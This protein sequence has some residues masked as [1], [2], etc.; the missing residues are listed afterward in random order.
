MKEFLEKISSYNLFN[1]LLPGI[2]FVVLCKYF[3]SLDIVQKDLVIGVFFYYFIGL[4]I[5]RLGSLIIEPI[6]KKIKFVIF[7]PYK[8]F[9]SASEKDAKLEVLSEVN[10]MYRTFSSLFLI[11]IFIKFYESLASRWSFI[12]QWTS[13]LL[14]VCFIVLFLF[15]YKKQT[16]YIK[17]RVEKYLTKE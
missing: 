13:E 8:D 16:Q 5:S 1:Y 15:S 17:R 9:I 10:N 7:A 14:I 12:I 2:I 6:L 4:I 3:T 11:I